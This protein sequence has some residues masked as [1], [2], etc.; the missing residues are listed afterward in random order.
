MCVPQKDVERFLK[1]NGLLKYDSWRAISDKYFLGYKFM[2]VLNY[3][4]NGFLNLVQ[5]AENAF[6]I[7]QN[8][9]FIQKSA[10]FA[11]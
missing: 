2:L 1:A 10:N 5:A 8:G 6:F 4:K 3:E 7:F 11:A 9:M